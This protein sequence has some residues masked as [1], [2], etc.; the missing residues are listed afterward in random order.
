MNSVAIAI[1]AACLSA[2]FVGQRLYIPVKKLVY[3][4]RWKDRRLKPLDC[5]L[6]LAW[7]AGLAGG[8]YFGKNCL[9]VI[10]IGACAAVLAVAITKHLNK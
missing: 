7:W 8:I 2:V 9:E 1:G 10:Y 6:C 4:S 5:E 3:K